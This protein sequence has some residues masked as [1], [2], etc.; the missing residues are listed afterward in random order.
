M[1][2]VKVAFEGVMSNHFSTLNH[3][4]SKPEDEWQK[5]VRNTF[6]VALEK[7]AVH[8]MRRHHKVGLSPTTFKLIIA[9]KVAHLARL[10]VDV[11]LVSKATYKV[12]NE[13]VKKVVARDVIIYLKHQANTASCFHEQG[14][15]GDWA[16][17]AKHMATW[18]TSTKCGAP[19]ALL[20]QQGLLIHNLEALVQRFYKHFANVLR[21]NRDLPEETHVQLDA[22]MC[23]IEAS[24]NT[25]GDAAKEPTLSEVVDCVKKLRNITT[26]G[27]DGIISPFVQGVF[28]CSLLVTPGDFNGLEVKAGP[29]SL[30]T[31]TCSAII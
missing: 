10:G 22:K 8:K 1:P 17:Q 23:E 20:N 25:Q 18:G 26:P 30:E 12:A 19:K 13:M 5:W 4:A 27:E 2:E 11:S 9:K 21:G 28:C 3:E 24:L 29:G 14:C 6:V 15:T 31:C 16:R 7:V